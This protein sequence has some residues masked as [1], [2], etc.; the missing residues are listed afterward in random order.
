M[1]KSVLVAFLASLAVVS[2]DQDY[3]T[4]VSM[5]QLS[6]GGSGCPQGTLSQSFSQDRKT[7]T[8]IFDQFYA[9]LEQGKP[10][11]DSRKNCQ[12]NVPVKIPQGWQFSILSTDYRG[13]VQLDR[14]LHAQHKSTYY[15]AGQS[16]QVSSTCDFYGPTARDY[17]SHNDVGVESWSPCGTSANLNVNAQVRLLNESGPASAKGQITND[18]TDGKF[19]QMLGLR[20]KRC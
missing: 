9:S 2:A 11:T 12:I 4:D 13:Y 16:E 1:M 15:F 20:W 19:K 17:L 3:P 18:S 5:G 7:F 8:L 6:Y 14:G 10:I